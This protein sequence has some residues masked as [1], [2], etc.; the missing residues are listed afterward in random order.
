MATIDQ[1]QPIADSIIKAH[2][3]NISITR[4]TAVNPN[5]SLTDGYRIGALVAKHR[6]TEL[7]EKIVGYKIG[8]TNK[9]TWA[10]IGAEAPVWAPMY[11][12]TVQEASQKGVCDIG[13]LSGV[14]MEPEIAFR[15]SSGVTSELSLDELWVSIDGVAFGYEVVSFPFEKNG[16]TT[17]DLAATRGAHNFY[18][19]AP[20]KPLSVLGNT[21]DE[22][23]ETLNNIS[24]S[25]ESQGQKSY[26][27]KSTDVLSSPLFALAEFIRLFE[28]YD[29][30]KVGLHKGDIITTGS[31]TT[32]APVSTGQVWT[33][34][35]Q[36]A[37]LST[38]LIEFV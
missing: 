20:F 10:M 24:L 14:L 1:L 37:P 31:L 8:L 9:A 18:V 25:M 30:N 29:F 2:L 38:P 34:K 32:P 4:P 21:K 7:H 27:G 5:L 11:S 13:K 16:L 33:V 28:K 26:V 22:Q 3:D 35:L 12:T 19:H 36:G 15:L 6:Q 17:V 23:V